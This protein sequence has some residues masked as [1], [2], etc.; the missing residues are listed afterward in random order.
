MST[1][2]VSYQRTYAALGTAD[3]RKTYIRDTIVVDDT[4][5]GADVP[6]LLP[7]IGTAYAPVGLRAAVIKASDVAHAIAITPDVIDAIS[8]NTPA[9]FPDFG[10]PGTANT[11][12]LPPG[13]PG[14][15]TI[16]A[17]NMNLTGSVQPNSAGGRPTTPGAWLI[18]ASSGPAPGPDDHKVSATVADTTPNYLALKL[19]AGTGITLVLLNPGANEQVEIN[20]TSPSPFPVADN[21]FEVEN[22]VDPTKTLIFDLSLQATA[23]QQKISSKSLISRLFKLPNITGTAVVEE[24]TTG[25]VLMGSDVPLPLAPDTP[26][27]AGMQFSSAISGRSQLR[28]NQYGANNAAP[29]LSAFKS[30]GA[31]V[32]VQAGIAAGDPLLRLTA[33]NVAPNNVNIPIAGFVTIQVANGFVPAAQ[34]YTASELEIQLVPLAGPINGRRVSFRITSEGETQTLRGIRAGGP[35]TVAPVAGNPIPGTLWSSSTA[36]T[37][38][39]VI[40]GSPGD[41]F[42]STTGGAGAT[43]WVKETGV[44]TNIGWVAK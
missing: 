3:L 40:V 44:A 13:T 24:D 41:L 6:L 20:A 15:V 29:G 19:A 8:S 43:L 21:V 38:N 5:A 34:N 27:A 9:A 35:L 26:S 18:V 32:G 33:T 16:E 37:P 1:P 28:V 17:T 36:P 10:T 7:K 39:G 4:G 11:S 14:A 42:S 12:A 23:T 25:F 30:R 31:A 22:A 2:P